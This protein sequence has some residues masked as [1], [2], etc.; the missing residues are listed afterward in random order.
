MAGIF[1]HLNLNDT[2][3]VFNATV[4]QRAIYEAAAAYL[5][6]VN[7]D[8]ERALPVFVSGETSDHKLRYKLPGGGR[9]QKRQSDGSYGAT[10]ALGQWDVAFP[11]E[12]FGAQVAYNDVDRAYMTVA[13]LDR[14]LETV[15]IQNVNTVRFQLLKALL[16][17]TQD[18]FVDPLWGSLSIEPLANGDA[19]TYPPV[20][21]SESEATDDHYLESNY[22]ATAISDSNNPYET[23]VEELLEHFGESTGGDNVTTFIH[24]DEAPET[25]DLT[26]FT[27]VPDQFIRSGDNVDIPERLPSVPGKIIGRMTGPGACWVVQWRWIPT[28]YMLAVHLEEDAPLMRRVDPA[29]TGLPRGLNLVANNE[30]FPFEGSFW[31]NRFGYGV[32]NRL[33]G[34]VMELATGGTY[35]VPTA[36]Q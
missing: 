20:L 9:L 10:K 11:L 18:T 13:E 31:R 8:I 23:I 14:H 30:E 16:N 22:A 35:T 6:R 32:G 19:V 2:D 17:N 12:D 24:P 7:A 29:D 5:A 3:R 36:Y 26:D 27:E 4:G 21:G 33:N 28:G 15:A 34:V 25:L 1:G